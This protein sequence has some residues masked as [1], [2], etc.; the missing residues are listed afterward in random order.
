MTR[1]KPRLGASSLDLPLFDP[2]R[3]TDLNSYTASEELSSH[4]PGFGASDLG[5][6]LV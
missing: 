1:L 5:Y 4:N 2:S 6:A 3:P